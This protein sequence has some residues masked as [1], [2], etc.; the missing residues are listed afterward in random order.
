MTMN[1][2]ETETARH[3]ENQAAELA[4]AWL[5]GQHEHVRTAIRS[6]E[7]QAYLAASITAILCGG[8]E[9]EEAVAFVDFMHPNE[10]GKEA[11]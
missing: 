2:P 3:Y 9:S 1:H 11:A 7:I 10:T 8:D 4:Q 5:A 6:S